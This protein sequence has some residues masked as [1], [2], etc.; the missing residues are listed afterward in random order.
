MGR[1]GRKT[2]RDPGAIDALLGGAAASA[3][4]IKRRHVFVSAAEGKGRASSVVVQIV[5]H[6]SHHF[7][8]D[9]GR[10]ASAV[11]PVAAAAIV[12]GRTASTLISIL[13]GLARQVRSPAAISITSLQSPATARFLRDGGIGVTNCL[14]R[15]RVLAIVVF[16]LTVTDRGSTRLVPFVRGDLIRRTVAVP[17]R[18]PSTAP[19]ADV[20]VHIGLFSSYGPVSGKAVVVPVSLDGTVPALSDL[21]G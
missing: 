7:G 12:L 17:C 10:T 11:L 1:T 20:R 14:A 9:Y 21:V 5:C 18:R 15:K 4:F 8:L 2:K 19:R 3:I 13:R 16:G 6:R